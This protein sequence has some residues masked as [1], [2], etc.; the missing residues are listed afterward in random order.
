[1]ATA[2]RA[3]EVGRPVALRHWTLVPQHEGIRPVSA[4]M[5]VEPKTISATESQGPATATRAN[6][7]ADGPIPVLDPGAM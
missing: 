7:E 1:M 2:S 6:H 3:A 4:R 5:I